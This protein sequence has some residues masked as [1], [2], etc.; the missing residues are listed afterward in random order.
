MLPEEL[1]VHG[2]KDGPLLHAD[3]VGMPQNRLKQPGPDAL[4]LVRPIH[5]EIPYGHDEGVVGQ[6]PGERAYLWT[7]P[8]AEHGVAVV[9][10]LRDLVGRP[11]LAPVG[12]F[13]EL[14]DG[15][16]VDRLLEAQAEVGHRFQ[17]LVPGS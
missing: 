6:N 2:R 16:R 17:R 12:L 4:P 8:H 9:D 1:L 3:H 11:T 5:H 14:L 13:K 7:V 10:L 15:L